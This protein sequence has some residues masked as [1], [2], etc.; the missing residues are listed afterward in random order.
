MLSRLD[1][2]LDRMGAKLGALVVFKRVTLTNAPRTEGG[3][4]RPGSGKGRKAEPRQKTADRDA[5]VPK[6]IA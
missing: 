3:A 5:C 4:G 6:P 1:E 2:H